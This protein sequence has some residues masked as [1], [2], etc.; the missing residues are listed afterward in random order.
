[1]TVP[2]GQPKARHDNA[3]RGFQGLLPPRPLAEDLIRPRFGGCP[4]YPSHTNVRGGRIQWGRI[5][6]QPSTA[7]VHPCSR[8]TEAYEVSRRRLVFQARLPPR[9][10]DSA[11]DRAQFV[12]SGI[13]FR[14]ASDAPAAD[15]GERI[16]GTSPAP[17]PGSGRDGGIYGPRRYRSRNY[18]EQPPSSAYPF[19]SKRPFVG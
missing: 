4:L 2:H 6:P 19:C 13:R 7:G 18:L 9:R 16:D 12:T 11:V 15:V 3:T 1:M 8:L 5:T 14:E 10:M 17:I